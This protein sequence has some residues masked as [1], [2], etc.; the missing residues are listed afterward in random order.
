M[1]LA[2]LS[3]SRSS[4]RHKERAKTSPQCV[5]KEVVTRKGGRRRWLG[6]TSEDA[7]LCLGAAS[8]LSQPEHQPQGWGAGGAKLGEF[9]FAWME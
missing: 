6:C 4:K 1:A 3:S 2:E 7:T 5:G 9:G 8:V